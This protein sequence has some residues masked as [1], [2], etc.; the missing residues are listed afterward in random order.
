MTSRGLSCLGCQHNGFLLKRCRGPWFLLS[1]YGR[2]Q[3]RLLYGF[4]EV[5]DG[6]VVYIISVCGSVIVVYGISV[7]YVAV[8]YVISVCVGVVIV[9]SISVCCIT[10]VLVVSVC[11][12]VVVFYGISVYCVVVAYF[13]SVYGVVV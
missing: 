8:V 13:V 7:F 6:V 2:S 4:I 12:G 3:T 5:G 9:Y 1:A 10:V 11:G